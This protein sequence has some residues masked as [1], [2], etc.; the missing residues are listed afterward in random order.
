MIDDG[1]PGGDDDPDPDPDYCHYDCFGYHECRDGVVTTWDHTPVPC[2]YWEGECPHYESYECVEG[3]R[4]DTDQIADPWLDPAAMCE[5]NRPKQ[6]GDLCADES[7]CRPEVATWDQTG[8]VT[9]VYLTCDIA[10]GICVE[11]P[12]PVVPD[13]LAACGHVADPFP[14]SFAY[15]YV[16][17]D[18]C[19]GGVC[20]Y[21]ERE[22]CVAQGCSIRCESDGDCPMGAVCEPGWGVCKP[23]P[24][25]LIGVSL[26]CP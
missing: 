22:D 24:P 19:T 5:E 15:G 1:D 11:R 3:C 20:L 4:I 17:T 13:W 14:D 7:D 9:N 10:A 26:A 8:A 2:D 21:L 25:N 23:G 6:V 16:E 12:A 18:A